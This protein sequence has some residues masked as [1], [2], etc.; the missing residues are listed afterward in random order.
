MQKREILNDNYDNSTV[1]PICGF[2][3]FVLAPRELGNN[4]QNKTV[5]SIHGMLLC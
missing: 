3:N 1:F 2:Y 5:S 4:F